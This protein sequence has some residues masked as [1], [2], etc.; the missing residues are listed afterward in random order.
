[1][2]GV[3]AVI[4][5]RVIAPGLSVARGA[6]RIRDAAAAASHTLEVLIT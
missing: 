1:M 3:I 5:R 4:G 2:S 6:R